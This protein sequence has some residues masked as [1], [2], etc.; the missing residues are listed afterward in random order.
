MR[1]PWRESAGLVPWLIL[2][3][4]ALGIALMVKQWGLPKTISDNTRNLVDTLSTI[5]TTSLLVIG[6]ILSYL[7][8]FRGRTLSPKLIITSSTGVVADKNGF[9]HWIE[10]QIENKGS[11][12]VW[13]YEM[14]IDATLHGENEERVE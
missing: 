1:R 4:I 14:S 13:N 5:I 10:T 7:K 8:F 12:A 11:V 9:L 6:G 2:I 3:A